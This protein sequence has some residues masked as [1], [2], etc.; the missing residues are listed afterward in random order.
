MKVE[1]VD[2]HKAY[3]IERRKKSFKTG[4]VIGAIFSVA[5]DVFHYHDIKSQYKNISS[6]VGKSKAL[7]KT[8]GGV[9]FNLGATMLFYGALNVAFGA[10]IDKVMRLF[11]KKK[12]V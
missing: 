5:N 10:L 1:Q 3:K 7:I 9:M 12:E 11:N 4:A 8:G 6:S 2:A